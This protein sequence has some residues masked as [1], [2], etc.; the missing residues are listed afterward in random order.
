MA[1]LF[2][3]LE[4]GNAGT[5]ATRDNL[6]WGEDFH[7]FLSSHES[8]SPTSVLTCNMISA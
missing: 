5:I 6:T 2:L 4:F 3:P 8:F 7:H 1:C